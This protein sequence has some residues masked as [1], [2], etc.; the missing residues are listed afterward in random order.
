MGNGTGV[1]GMPVTGDFS[2]TGKLKTKKN[3]NILNLA[4]V[5]CSYNT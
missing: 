2:G 5:S 1:V 3:G 4:I